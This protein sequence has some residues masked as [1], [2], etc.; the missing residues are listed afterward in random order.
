[1]THPE[2]QGGV[3]VRH[4]PAAAQAG[5]AWSLLCRFCLRMQRPTPKVALEMCVLCAF[6]RMFLIF[7]SVLSRF[8]YAAFVLGSTVSI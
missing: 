1:M 3:P 8:L 6:G 4:I 2:G 7:I 5:K